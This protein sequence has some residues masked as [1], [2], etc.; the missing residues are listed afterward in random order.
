MEEEVAYDDDEEEENDHN[1]E[2]PQN[3]EITQNAMQLRDLLVT[4]VNSNVGRIR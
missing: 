4:Y 1:D 3:D 2:I